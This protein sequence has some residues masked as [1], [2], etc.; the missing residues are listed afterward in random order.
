MNLEQRLIQYVYDILDGDILACEKHKWA[1]QRFLNDL[2]RTQEDDCW[3]YFDI[4]QLYDFYEWSKQFK[5]FKGVIAGQPIK[6]TDLQLFIAA[7]IFCFLNKET[8]KRRFLRVFIELA[9]K[10]AKSLFLALIGSYITYLSE[11]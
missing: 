7:N 5:H 8:D 4:D 11:Q 2:E 10:N 3:F 9:R 1:C 6:L